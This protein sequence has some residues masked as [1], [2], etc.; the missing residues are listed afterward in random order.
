MIA[1]ANVSLS[2]P[3]LVDQVRPMVVPL[4]SRQAPFEV[5]SA[6][7]FVGHPVRAFLGS[8]A[9]GSPQFLF[10]GGCCG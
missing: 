10:P 6:S 5:R 7:W 3:S 4:I 1:A 8:G 9:A 2:F